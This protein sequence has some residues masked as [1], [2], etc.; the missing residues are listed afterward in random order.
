MRLLHPF[1]RIET[2]TSRQHV[3]E[4]VEAAARTCYKSEGK[5]GPGTAEKL[6]A[7]CIRRG[8]ESV[9]EHESLQV[10]FVID[11][12]ISHELVRH[13]L[14]AFSQE[15]TRYCRYDDHVQFIIPVGFN[16]KP[17]EYRKTED[18]LYVPVDTPEH[19]WVRAIMECE[20]RYQDL[21]KIGVAPEIARDVLPMSLKTELVMTA[22]LREWR[23]ILR[24]RTASAAHP[25]MREVMV[26]LLDRMAELLPVIFED[27]REKTQ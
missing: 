15:S 2:L 3:Y 16:I 8:H 21:L 11:R 22:N 7:Q 18:F 23:H 27:L 4:S 6:I 13:R 14:A 17:G 10:R 19:H 1:A 12:G 24:L 20:A 5:Q 9:L 26:S 25:Q